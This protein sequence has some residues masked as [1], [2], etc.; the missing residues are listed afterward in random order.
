MSVRLYNGACGLE[1][2]VRKSLKPPAFYRPQL[3]YSA[4]VNNSM[5]VGNGYCEHRLV[6][7]FHPSAVLTRIFFLG[8]KNST[9]LFLHQYS[10]SRASVITYTRVIPCEYTACKFCQLGIGIKVYIQTRLAASA[11]RACNTMLQSGRPSAARMPHIKAT[12][13]ALRYCCAV[14]GVHS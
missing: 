6:G 10:R 2:L 1:L 11:A 4:L 9:R 12:A 14:C 3:A 13:R 7:I 5:S 8:T